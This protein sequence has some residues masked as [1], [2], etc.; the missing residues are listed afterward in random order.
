MS[1][2]I[3]KMAEVIKGKFRGNIPATYYV[4]P[5][6]RLFVAFDKS[7]NKFLSGWKLSSKQLRGLLE[8]RYTQ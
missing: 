5:E 6:T 7:D 8:D 4:N 2:E 3:C 1:G